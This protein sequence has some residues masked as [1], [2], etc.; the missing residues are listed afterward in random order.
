MRRFFVN[1]VILSLAYSLLAFSF[2]YAL[3]EKYI[4]EEKKGIEFALNGDLESATT[5]FREVLQIAPDAYTARSLLDLIQK[6]NENQVTEK[7]YSLTMKASYA[8]AKGEFNEAIDMLKRVT[9]DAPAFAYPFIEIGACYISKQ[10]PAEAIP[11][12]E[13]AI[14]LEPNNPIIHL[15]FGGVYAG[16]KEYGQA[17]DSLV[18]YQA[19][20]S[21]PSPSSYYLLGVSYKETGH[22]EL[23]I[24]SFNESLLIDPESPFKQYIHG[25]LAELYF[26]SQDY[27]SSIKHFNQ[28]K[29][30]GLDVSSLEE[31]LRPYR[32]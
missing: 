25:F 6:Y 21:E 18:K 15:L 12:F 32:K 1:A 7:V 3:D 14:S 29:E 8:E 26:D 22:A 20:V 10:M 19:L 24:K 23:A 4:I 31:R 30:L 17:I 9:D 16:Q 13:K 2:C 11:Y 28:A 5:S 27:E